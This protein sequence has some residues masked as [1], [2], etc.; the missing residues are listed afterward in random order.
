MI[1]QIL[2]KVTAR[3]NLNCD[4]CYVFNMGDQSWKDLPRL[5]SDNVI[6]GTIDFIQNNFTENDEVCI[7][8][9]GGEPLMYGPE[10]IINFMAQANARIGMPNLSFSLQTNMYGNNVIPW[11]KE[12]H[13]SGVDIS[14]STDGDRFSMDLHRR[15]RTGKSSFDS[16]NANL[17]EANEKNL[18]CGIISVVD[19]KTSAPNLLSYLSNFDVKLELLPIDTN[20]E[21][22]DPRIVVET[23]IWFSNAFLL[24]ISD[25]SSIEIRYFRHIIDRTRGIDVGT[26]AFGSGSLNLISIEPDGS[27]HGLDVLRGIDQSLSNTGFN[28]FNHNLRDVRNSSH[29]RLHSSLLMK[30][31]FPTSCRGCTYRDECHGGS[32]PHRWNGE[33]FDS[34]S[35]HCMTLHSLFTLT[36]ASAKVGTEFEFVHLLDSVFRQNDISKLIAIHCPESFSTETDTFYHNN[37][38]TTDD[39]I[40]E[41]L[42]HLGLQQHT[43]DEFAEAAVYDALLKINIWN[44][45]ISTYLLLNKVRIC[46]VHPITGPTDDLISLTDSRVE[47]SIFI[48]V[49][50]VQN[51]ALDPLNIGENII[52]ETV[53]LIVDCLY[54]GFEMSTS[55]EFDISVPWRKD[56][57]DVSGVLHGTTVF[58][59]L[60]SFRDA[61]GDVQQRDEMEKLVLAGFTA[62]EANRHRL[63]KEG[64]ALFNLMKEGPYADIR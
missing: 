27:I 43:L 11:L 44:P 51:Q 40:C 23:A 17:I 25:Y 20:W 7:T 55:R 49:V 37:I 15:T 50:G 12:L 28:I 59:V 35:A 48:N 42:N 2:V 46:S 4:Y 6:N 45:N 58:W 32:V 16:V 31:N 3:C 53:H 18:L 24:W 19:P 9:H 10:P 57:R 52:H 26:D 30:N 39:K 8:F 33:N 54:R 1:N 63:T 60:R 29:F 5:M 34:K 36:S 21:V 13:K 62:L 22:V 14:A 38:F 61:F 56:L 47:N 64:L 41:I